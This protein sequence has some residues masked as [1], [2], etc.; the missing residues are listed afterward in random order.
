MSESDQNIKCFI[1]MTLNNEI[2]WETLTSF[3]N[4]LSSTLE[5]SKLINQILLEEL[6]SMNS[7]LHDK[8]F[9]NNSTLNKPDCSVS[10]DCNVFIEKENASGVTIKT[11]FNEDQ[12]E[13]LQG[14]EEILIKPDF[15]NE[16]QEKHQDS[17]VEKWYQN[18]KPDNFEGQNILLE[19]QNELREISEE[20]PLQCKTCAKTFSRRVHLEN[21]ERTHTGEKPFQC[22]TCSKTFSEKSTLKRHERTHNGDKP[23]QCKTCSKSFSQS[24]TLKT[25]ERSHTGEKPFQCNTCGKGFSHSISLMRHE[26]VHSGEKTFQ[27]H[28]CSQRFTQLSSLK[29]HKC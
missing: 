22:K 10:N 3:L 13:E 6:K 4:D 29:S 18:V 21:H 7:K 24:G 23:F 25:H 27:C 14:S 15:Q 2:S 9:E 26:T 8:Q 28:K 19:P 5:K 16:E 20:N 11:D 1:G 12:S 17:E